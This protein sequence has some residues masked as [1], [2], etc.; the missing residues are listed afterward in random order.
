MVEGDGGSGVGGREG[1]RMEVNE[2]GDGLGVR[3][4]DGGPR[5]EGSTRAL[6]ACRTQ[7]QCQCQDGGE[8]HRRTSTAVL[9]LEGGKVAG[10]WVYGS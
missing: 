5:G 9:T 4:P 1:E 6:L 3:P 7:H 10:G 8:A 2:W